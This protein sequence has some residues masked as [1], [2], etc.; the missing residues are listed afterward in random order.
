MKRPEIAVTGIGML[1]PAGIGVEATWRGVCDGTPTAATDGRLTGLTVDFCCS[2]PS[3]DADA[4]VGRRTARRLDRSTQLV[5][6]AAKEA[7]HDA[8]LSPS[9][10]DSTRVGVVTGL[11][12]GASQTWESQADQMRERGPRQVSPLMITMI[13]PSAVAGEVALACQAHGPSLM[14]ATACASGATALALARD[15]LTTG[16]C[17]I[18]LAGGT[19]SCNTPL[20][21]AGLAQLGALSTR[22]DDPAVASRPF[23]RG[24][25]GFVLGEA[26]AVLVLERAEDATARGHRPRALL[27][28]CGSTTDAYHPTA[29]HPE[30]RGAK[31]AMR[32]ALAD[33]GLTPRDI[34]YVN[35][36]GTSTLL[37]DTVEADTISTVLPHGPFVTSTKGVLGHSLGATGAV[38][39]ALTILSI[40]KSLIPPT[41]NLEN[42]DLGCELNLVSKAAAEHRVDVALSNSF[43]FGGHNVVLAFRAP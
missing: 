3:F 17:D 5:I 26:A 38:E 13:G 41:A 31:Q 1:T 22:C 8:A 15:M 36:H 2:I 12:L 24:R 39:A 25:D 30:G 19:E 27:A 18:V 9:T 35:A 21:V 28:G 23:D 7:L 4:S 34:D 42:P 43:G 37:N 20:I 10:W 29:P 32:L 33:A 40:Q 11:A 16:E 6:A 14:T